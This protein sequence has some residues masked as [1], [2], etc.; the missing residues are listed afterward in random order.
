[1]MDAPVV[2]NRRVDANLAGHQQAHP[3]ELSVLIS[4]VG[5]HLNTPPFVS[6]FTP[7]SLPC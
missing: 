7:H 5:L 4:N 3:E 6:G 2:G 1:M